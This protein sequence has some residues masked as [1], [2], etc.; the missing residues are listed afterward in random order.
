MS[1]VV[2]HHFSEAWEPGISGSCN[3]NSTSDGDLIVSEQL[4]YSVIGDLV[5]AESLELAAEL[6]S[7][8]KLSCGSPESIVVPFEATKADGTPE[9]IVQFYI[10]QPKGGHSSSETEAHLRRICRAGFDW[11]MSVSDADDL[12]NFE[13]RFANH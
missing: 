10:H 1:V 4:E 3:L 13:L 7:T 5:P 11:E 8:L 6:P 12:L 2:R 9:S